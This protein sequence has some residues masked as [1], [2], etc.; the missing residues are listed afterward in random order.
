MLADFK[1]DALVS[2]DTTYSFDLVSMCDLATNWSNISSVSRNEFP[3]SGVVF[4][5]HGKEEKIKC[6]RIQT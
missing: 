5:T 6:E 3:V 2:P 4:N 1:N